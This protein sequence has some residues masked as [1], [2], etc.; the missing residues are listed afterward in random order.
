MK[1][2]FVDYNLDETLSTLR[3]A[4]R[5]RK[6]K[7]KPIV[8]QDPKVA[9][10]NRLN[11]LVQE[12]RLALM[13]RELGTINPKE[14]EALEDKYRVLQHKFRDMTEKLNSNL[15]EIVV[16]H[17]R[18][19]MAEQAREKIRFAMALLLD[20]VKQVLQDF[21]TCPEIDNEKRD[22][23]RA[24]YEKMLGERAFLTYIYIY[25]PSVNYV[26]YLS[27]KLLTINFLESLGNSFHFTRRYSKRRKESIRGTYKS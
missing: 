25:E 24:I 26:K 7:N 1:S 3:Y 19:E 23:L 22:K 9:E 16:M 11:K 12:L 13:N 4:D 2:L 6:I 14:Q 15:G 27:P 8:N 20:D 17:E 5:A 18:A 10:I 21:D